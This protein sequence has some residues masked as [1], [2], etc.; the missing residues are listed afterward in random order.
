MALSSLSRTIMRL[1]QGPEATAIKVAVPA[2]FKHGRR[3][4]VRTSDDLRASRTLAGGES[5][6]RG[7]DACGQVGVAL[8]DQVIALLA[9]RCGLAAGQPEP[10]PG[11]PATP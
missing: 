9:H 10:A 5:F 6:C 8:I 3:C 4:M 11:G 1:A 2:P 7:G